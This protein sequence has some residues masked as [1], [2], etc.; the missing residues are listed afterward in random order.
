MQVVLLMSPQSC[1]LRRTNMNKM[2][3]TI[4]PEAAAVAEIEIREIQIT[5]LT[6]RHD[7][8]VKKEDKVKSTCSQTKKCQDGKALSFGK[9][10][11]FE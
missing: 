11:R 1:V 10:P 3:L 9:A 8:A 6:E 5:R 2:E 4:K 7:V